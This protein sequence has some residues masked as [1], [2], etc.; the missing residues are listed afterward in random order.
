MSLLGY[1]HLGLELVKF[2]IVEVLRTQTLDFCQHSLENFWVPA[3][4]PPQQTE[5]RQ[6]I[7]E[8]D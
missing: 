8:C 6:L 4:Q 2:L 5:A 1:E 3:L 7:S